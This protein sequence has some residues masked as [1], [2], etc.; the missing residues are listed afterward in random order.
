MGDGEDEA[1][2]AADDAEIEALIA[3]AG[4]IIL[5]EDETMEV[6]ATWKESR[7][8]AT[9]EKLRRG[10]PRDGGGGPRVGARPMAF[11]RQGMLTSQATK[12]KHCILSIQ[13]ANFVTQDCQIRCLTSPGMF[14]Q[15]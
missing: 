10:F 11:C 5:D 12:P 6:L 8:A 2:C 9:Q 15:E 1:E 7:T 13:N 3:S 4:D 14:I